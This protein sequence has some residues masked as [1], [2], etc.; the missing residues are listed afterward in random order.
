M[1]AEQLPG[2]GGRISGRIRAGAADRA[3]ALHR[4]G[5]HL[6][7]G[8]L[9]VSEYDERSGA[10]A[11]AVH[12]DE[13]DVLFGDLPAAAGASVAAAPEPARAARWFWWTASGTPVVALLLHLGTGSTWWYLLPVAGALVLF[14]SPPA[15]PQ[16]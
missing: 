12:L 10:A 16:R 7:E 8:R 14:A 5:T 1:S 4:L 9:T 11:R 13:L 15:R 3:A 2:N 6:A